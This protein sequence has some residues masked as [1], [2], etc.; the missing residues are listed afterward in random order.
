MQEVKISH[1]TLDESGTT[2]NSLIDGLESCWSFIIKFDTEVIPL[3]N[4]EQISK[5]THLL[6]EDMTSNK[7][8]CNEWVKIL[9][10][11][12]IQENRNFTMSL[13]N[14]VLARIG[15]LIPKSVTRRF[16]KYLNAVSISISSILYTSY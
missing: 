3:L 14:S 10:K 16:C 1:N 2:V 4:N 9:L 8:E 15:H 12:D 11:D 13:L 6:L 7:N 5:L